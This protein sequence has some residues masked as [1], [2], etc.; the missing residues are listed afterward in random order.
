[1]V[2]PLT[3]YAYAYPHPAVTTDVVVFTIELN[4]LKVLL[5]RRVNEPYAGMWALPGGFLGIEEDLEACARRE[6]AEETA[7]EGVYLEQ[8]CTFGNPGRDPRERVVSV[9]Y[10]ALVPIDA[11]EPRAASDASAVAWFDYTALPELAFDHAAI[12][13]Q[14]HK[15]LVAKLAYS[16]IAFQL[17]PATF[18]LS[19]AQQVYESLL[20]RALDKRNFRK[21]ILAL[22]CLR[23]TSDY[24]RNGNHR[25][26][27]IYRM[28]DPDRV[29]IIK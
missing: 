26:A 7:I 24:R 11:V 15:R 20:G 12:I 27:R 1:M 25:P 10:L 28:S 21:R 23:K 14:A 18:T 6:L 2:S 22:D 8:L 19:E 16:T 3:Q 17:L 9:T 29:D 4:A 13:A 5:V